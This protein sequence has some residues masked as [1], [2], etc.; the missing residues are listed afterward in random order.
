MWRLGKQ[1]RV[2]DRGVPRRGDYRVRLRLRTTAVNTFQQARTR[3]EYVEN[4]KNTGDTEPVTRRRRLLGAIRIAVGMFVLVT[5]VIQITDRLLNNAFDPRE[6]FSYFTIQSCLINIVVLL[7]G[8]V[9][10][11]R[12]RRDTVLY[13][14]IRMSIVAYAVVTAG[15]YN[16][17]LR[18]VPYEGFQGLQWP[19]EVLHV[20]V[21][22][23]IALDWLF[24]P[25]RP[26]LPWRTLLIPIGYPVLWLGFT[27][28]RGV[29]TDTYP[30][31][32][33]DPATA[34][35]GSVVTYIVA[36]TMFILAIAALCIAYSRR[37]GR[38]SR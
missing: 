26:P 1:R 32:F 21:P 4:A 29:F 28:V 16:L 31:P 34:G 20:W 17:L 35:W 13:T 23:F 15:V 14:S 36:L 8:G 2:D 22:I 18:S 9:M 3:A 30:Y 38:A 6:Y 24:A 10:A 33:I 11:L 25:G 37:G 19:N 5:V 27:L 12:H 7:V